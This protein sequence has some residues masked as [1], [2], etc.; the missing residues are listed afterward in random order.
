M[1]IYILVAVGAFLWLCIKR[2]RKSEGELLLCTTEHARV[3]PVKHA[4]RYPLL[5]AYVP[6]RRELEH[7]NPLFAIDKC[8]VLQ[9]QTKDYLGAP[10]GTFTLLEKLNWHLRRHV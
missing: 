1:M 3:L 5:Y 9:I 4:F 8:R 7:C 6:L 2:L 10:P